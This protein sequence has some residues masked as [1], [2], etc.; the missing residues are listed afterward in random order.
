MATSADYYQ[1]LKYVKNTRVQPVFLNENGGA[2]ATLPIN[3]TN[4]N[5]SL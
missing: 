1:Y 3:F 5:I 4:H 2:T